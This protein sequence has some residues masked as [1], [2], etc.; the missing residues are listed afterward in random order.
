MSKAAPTSQVG[1]ILE[2][3]TAPLNL[4][5]GRM[6]AGFVA[7]ALSLA[8]LVQATTYTVGTLDEPGPGIVPIVV[9]IV[10]A[11]AGITV[12]I[13]AAA[14][15]RDEAEEIP[16]GSDRRRLLLCLFYLLLYLLALPWAGDMIA[17]FGLGVA[18]MR[19]LS[20][21]SWP[22]IVIYAAIIAVVCHFFFVTLLEVQMPRGI[23]AG[24][25]F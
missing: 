20:S 7:L 23:T 6:I 24:L 1:V 12:L 10:M 14:I 13:D 3:E 4:R 18:T 17:A 15:P 16:A 9:G 21:R 11:L 8:Y 25:G 2:A 22:R 19:T 5:R